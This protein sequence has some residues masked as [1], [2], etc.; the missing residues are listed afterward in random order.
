MKIEKDVTYHQLRL[1]SWL[2]MTI[3]EWLLNHLE[4]IIF[5]L[6]LTMYYIIITHRRKISKMKQLIA[7]FYKTEIKWTKKMATTTFS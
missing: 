5:K 3:K 6:E 2:D 7:K 1:T 4:W